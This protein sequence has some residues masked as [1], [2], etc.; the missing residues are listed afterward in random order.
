MLVFFWDM[1]IIMLKVNI[2]F[3]D[4]YI[5]DLTRAGREMT[6]S[7]ILTGFIVSCLTKSVGYN[8]Q[9]T[10]TIVDNLSE[11]PIKM[12]S[13]IFGTKFISGVIMFIIIR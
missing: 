5:D 13:F 8:P 12:I 6:M 7:Q 10:Y 1:M 2:G 3:Y 11:E 4:R 9:L